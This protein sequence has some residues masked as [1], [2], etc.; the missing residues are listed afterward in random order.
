MTHTPSFTPPSLRDGMRWRGM[1][2]GLLGGS[3]NPPHEG[4]MHIAHIAMAK[5]GLDFVWWII[6]PQNPLKKTN[7]MAPYEERFARVRDLTATHPRMMATHLERDLGTRYTWQT[8]KGL[9][10]G[11]PH[12]DFVWI[13][14]MDNAMIFHKWDRWRSLIDDIPI[15]FIARPPAGALIKGCPVRMLPGNMQAH[16]AHGVKTGLNPPRITWLQGAKMVDISSTKIR[17]NPLKTDK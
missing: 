6:T 1:R 8:V 4:H 12:T 11:F 17:N 16:G 2:V 3:F 5:F 7:G 15:V 13:C 9:K 10:Q 14:G